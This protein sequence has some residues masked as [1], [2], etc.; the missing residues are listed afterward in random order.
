MPRIE[1]EE[2]GLE[3]EAHFYNPKNEKKS[4]MT[5]E[6]LLQF[7]RLTLAS[8]SPVKREEVVGKCGLLATE[9]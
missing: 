3:W 7:A 1:F 8:L 6:F 2:L 9:L 5:S 4:I